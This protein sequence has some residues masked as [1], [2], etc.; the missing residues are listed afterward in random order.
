MVAA[1]EDVDSYTLTSSKGS[2]KIS[3]NLKEN[4]KMSSQEVADEWLEE[5][6]D[7]TG[8][9]LD[10]TV[11]SQ[12]S[13]MMLTS[14]GGSVTLAST[15]LDD[16]KEAV[17]ALQEKAW[18]IPGVLNVSSDAGEGATQIRVVIDPLDAMAHGMTPIQA[19]GGL[20]SMISG[21]EAMTITSNGEEYSVML[22]YPEGAYTK[23]SSL[24]DASI[25]G[26]PL[27]EMATLQY[28][29]SQQTV[30]KQDGKYT[31]T[32]TAS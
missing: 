13:T 18:N 17:S 9:Q 12:M 8:V 10:I 3:V 2:G 26:V 4:R 19:A 14:S 21:T 20:Y 1:H 24:L 28:T 15:N 5:T 23:A 16:L 25:G 30:M 22:E 31:T 6:K 27:S 7:M 11:S 32:I 29:D